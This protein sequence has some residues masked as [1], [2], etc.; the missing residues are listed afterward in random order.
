MK[1]NLHTHSLF[2]DGKSSHEQ[3]VVSAMEKGFDSIGFSGHGYTAF[4]NRYCMQDTEGYIKETLSVKEKYKDRI[5]VYLGVEEDMLGQVDR[6]R[7]DYIIGSCHYYQIDGRYYDVD[8]SYEEVLKAL[9]ATGGDAVKLAE[10]Y[11][12]RFCDYIMSRKPDIVG[13]F[14]LL[15]KY[16]EKYDAVF[17]GNKKYEALAEKY[18]LYA[19]KSGCIFEV[20]TGAISRGYRKT[21]YP[22]GNLLYTLCKNGGR[23]VVNSDCHSADGVDCAFEE[24]FALVREAGFKSTYMFNGEKFVEVDI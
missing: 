18:L 6:S 23:I 4:D 9:E 13:H 3:T 22:T 12:S 10:N 20:N 15:T 11:Y 1:S 14:D 8:D 17:L 24:A 7:F 2:C 16:D 5:R 19:I 21:P